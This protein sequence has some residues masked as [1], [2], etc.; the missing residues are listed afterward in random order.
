MYMRTKVATN[1]ADDRAKG[2]ECTNDEVGGLWGLVRKDLEQVLEF[3]GQWLIELHW[4]A[5]LR[6]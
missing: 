3:S 6:M 5:R 1:E 4:F 2:H